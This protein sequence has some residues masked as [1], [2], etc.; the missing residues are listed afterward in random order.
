MGVASAAPENAETHLVVS[1][2]SLD[3]GSGQ[4]T[5]LTA[6]LFD[7]ENN[8]LP[9]KVISWDV[10]FGSVDSEN[11]LT[12]DSGQVSVTYTAPVTTEEK[13]DNISATFAGDA[14]Y[15]ASSD[16][17][18]VH[19]VP[20]NV[21]E[22]ENVEKTSTQL[23][24]S[25]SSF[26]LKSGQGIALTAT[27]TSGGNPLKGK[28]ITWSKTAGSLSKVSGTTNDSGQVGVIY[29]SPPAE[30]FAENENQIVATVTASFAG[31]AQYQLSSG[32]CTGTVSVAVDV[33]QDSMDDGWETQNGLDPNINDAD[34]DADG[35]GYTNIEE[36]QAG[37]DPKSASSYPG[38]EK[39]VETPPTEGM[40]PTVILAIAV[41]ALI[42]MVSAIGISKKRARG[43]QR[44]SFPGA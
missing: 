40:S 10:V 23:M 13:W 28:T 27:L 2:S 32:S 35:D 3:I 18:N 9:N 34:Q 33:D 22:N 5:T 37:T 30:N 43:I 25:P 41:V 15:L 19:V 1:P 6:T 21:P 24:V 17:A 16:G 7:S 44:K 20:E 38:A 12:D 26:S 42:V 31:D 8:L 4:S 14:Q 39:K 29:T 36:Y 11:G